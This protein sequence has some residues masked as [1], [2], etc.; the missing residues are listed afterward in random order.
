M[1]PL[2]AVYSPIYRNVVFPL[3]EGLRGRNTYRYLKENERRPFMS[4]K[5]IESLQRRKLREVV[6]YAYEHTTFYRRLLDER[7]VAVERVNGIEG[8]RDADVWTSKET[9]REAGDDILSNEFSKNEL[10]DTATG[11]STGKPVTFYMTFDEWTLKMAVKYRGESWAGKPI[12]TPATIIWGHDLKPNWFSWK[13]YLLYWRLQKYQFLSAFKVGDRDL[14][15]YVR[16]IKRN[17]SKFLESYVTVV[18]N[19]ALTIER[20]GLKPPHLDGIIVGGERLYDFQKEKIEQVFQ[21]PV[22]NRYGCTEFSNVAH[23]CREHDGMHI[24]ADR[25]VVEVVDDSGAPVYDEAGDIVITDLDSRA[26]P[27]IRYRIGDRGAM[28]KERCRCGNNFPILRNVVG[29][30]SEVLVTPTG[31]QIHD[32]FFIWL[33]SRM[34]GVTRFKIVQ[35]SVS[36][37]RFDLVHDGS[38]ERDATVRF[39]EERLADLLDMGFHFSYNFVDEIPLTE[40]G[41]MLYFV[42]QIR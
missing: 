12:G 19:M 29:R 6:R 30:V 10:H 5:E 22:F 31:E 35:T 37:L 8:L 42:S 20:Y 33:L 41:K 3:Y 1:N 17:G 28:T 26:M 7:G 36:E 18:Y 25:V 2:T 21:C 14:V 39:I 13:K 27:L 34:P 38:V 16:R 15:D 24:N 32:L 40:S 23:E 4:P 9:V 11:V